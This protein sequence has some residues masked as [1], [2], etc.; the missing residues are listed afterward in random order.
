MKEYF[1]ADMICLHK[2]IFDFEVSMGKACLMHLFQAFYKIQK[3]LGSLLKCK[4]Q[5][6]IFLK[7]VSHISSAAVLFD[8]VVTL[9]SFKYFFQLNDIVAVNFFHDFALNLNLSLDL[10]F[11]PDIFADLFDCKLFTL[12]VLYQEYVTKATC[13]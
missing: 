1:I 2:N 3:Y 6:S 11:V 5:F 8:D 10:T 4:N 13:T 9:L 12:W 7:K